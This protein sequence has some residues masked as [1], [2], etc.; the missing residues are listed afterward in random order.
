MIG[1][2][3]LWAVYKAESARLKVIP[4]AANA[5]DHLQVLRQLIFAVEGGL[6]ITA[7]VFDREKQKSKTQSK[8]KAKRKQNESLRS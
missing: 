5:L 6:A 4:I 1:S 2:R 3:A 7:N 8:T